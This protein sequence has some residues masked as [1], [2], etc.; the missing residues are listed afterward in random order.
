MPS[1]ELRG[2]VD[3]GDDPPEAEKQGLDFDVL[4][5]YRTEK[6]VRILDRYL[7]LLYWFIVSLVVLYVVV[8]ALMVNGKH[9]IRRAGVGT[10][11]T[12]FHG[13][14]FADG[15]AYDDADLRYPEVE[16]AGA[17]ISTRT[18]TQKDQTVGECVDFDNAC[19]CR[20][21]EACVGEDP[22]YCKEVAW[23]PSLGPGNVEEIAKSTKVERMEGL[24]HTRLQLNAGIAFPGIGNEFFVAGRSTPKETNPVR[25]ITLGKLLEL[26]N[27]KLEDMI[28]EG[29]IIS[30]IFQWMCNVDLVNGCE[31]KVVVERI[32]GG[33]GFVTKRSRK[34][35]DDSG[36]AHRDA[37]MMYGLRLLVDSAGI[38]RQW[39]LVLV[40]I[41]LGSCLALMRTATM[42]ADFIMINLYPPHKRELYYK[43]KVKETKDYSDLKD[44]LNIIQDQREEVASLLSRGGAWQS[45]GL[46]AGGRGGIASSIM[47]R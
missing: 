47:A 29:A 33:R 19:P 18:V 5:A 37:Q 27:L 35:Y 1:R 42:C 11:V 16:P 32:D 43:C 3:D 31:L 25:K 41:Q 39:S 34:W 40:M 13:K 4:F 38:G 17:F 26:G 14:A 20:Q 21:E 24:E 8:F 6:I 28:D 9:T 22:G 15:M 36:K 7:G 30:V 10:V 45:L 44:R 12:K 23:C 46:G 2:F